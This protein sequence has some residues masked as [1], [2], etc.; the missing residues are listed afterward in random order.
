[1]GDDLRS[2]EVPVVDNEAYRLSRFHFE[3]PFFKKQ[4]SLCGVSTMTGGFSPWKQR[5]TA[6]DG[7]EPPPGNLCTISSDVNWQMM[8]IPNS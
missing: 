6:V 8:Q 3:L 4:V 7:I 1:M 5:S 2:T